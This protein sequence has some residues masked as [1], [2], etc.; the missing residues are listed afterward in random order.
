MSR[1]GF[2]SS[3]EKGAEATPVAATIESLPFDVFLF[4]PTVTNRLLEDQPIF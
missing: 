3:S 2:F 1:C 4:R